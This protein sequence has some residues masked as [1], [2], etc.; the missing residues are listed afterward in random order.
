[1]RRCA[2]Q[3]LGGHDLI[4][5]GLYHVRAGDEHVG[6]ILHHEDE[7]GHGGGIDRATR[8]RPHDDRDLRH[9]ARGHDV[10]LEHLGIACKAGYA[11]LNPRAAAVVQPDH[12]RAVLH[13]HVHDLA[14]LL[15]VGFGKRAAEDGEILAEHIDHAAVDRAPAGDDAVAR[16]AFRLHPEIRRAMGDEHVE[17]LERAIVQQKLDPLPRGQ[18]SARVLGV[19]PPLA[20]PQTRLLA[21][22]FKL[23]QNVFH[24]IHSSP[25]RHHGPADPNGKAARREA[26]SVKFANS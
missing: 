6:G 3:F 15:G 22:V 12:R 9:N 2:A 11:L 16:R 25:M 7:V 18:L 20:A 1:M 13:R 23:L 21:T 17:F 4:R 8:A 10:A 19:D 14:D 24:R 5:H 26:V